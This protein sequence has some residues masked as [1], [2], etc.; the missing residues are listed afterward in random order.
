MEDEVKERIGNCLLKLVV[1]P[2]L[3]H[4]VPDENRDV[5]EIVGNCIDQPVSSTLF[6][7]I[8]RVVKTGSRAE[9]LFL[10]KETDV[11][12]IYEIGPVKVKSEIDRAS[13]KFQLKYVKTVNSGFYSVDDQYGDSLYSTV[14]QTK[15]AP[16]VRSAL[17]DIA[18][19]EETKA[20]L[21]VEE[22]RSNETSIEDEQ[23]SNETWDGY[24]VIDMLSLTKAALQEKL[25]NHRSPFD[26]TSREDVVIALKVDSWP[27][28]VWKEF[29]MA[30]EKIWNRNVVQKLKG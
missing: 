16:M 12:Y 6:P 4:M 2:A 14:L 15:L 10:G 28:D 13:P 30:H 23:S 26:K 3:F 22:K 27:D 19:L 24:S 29:S 25:S 17:K 5:Y 21:P 18:L 1:F 20:A 11:D 8:T 7:M 9:Q